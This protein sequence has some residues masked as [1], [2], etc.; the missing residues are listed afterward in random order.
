[1]CDASYWVSKLN[2]PENSKFASL[3]ELIKRRKVN[4]EER[5]HLSKGLWIVFDDLDSH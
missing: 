3:A 2:F 5:L 1:M 4:K